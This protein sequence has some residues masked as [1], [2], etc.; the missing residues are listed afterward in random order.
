MSIVILV[1]CNRYFQSTRL[2]IK[3]PL[4]SVGGAHVVDMRS[5]CIL[6]RRVVFVSKSVVFMISTK[7]LENGRGRML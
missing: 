6:V 4:E 3:L 2:A 1:N 7:W 5:R